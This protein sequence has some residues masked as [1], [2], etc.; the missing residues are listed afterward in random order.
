MRSWPCVRRAAAQRSAES[1]GRS[2]WNASALDSQRPIEHITYERE[3]TRD[4]TEMR[5]RII[6][7][8]GEAPDADEAPD[9]VPDKLAETPN[10]NS[11]CVFVDNTALSEFGRL[12]MLLC[13]R[14][15]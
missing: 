6:K 15:M 13:F 11:S 10:G 5:W 2:P 1:S 12:A 3:P 7:N 8:L 14:Q 9:Q 4:E